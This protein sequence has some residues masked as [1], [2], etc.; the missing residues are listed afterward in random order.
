MSAEIANP[1][2]GH[3]RVSPWLSFR[4]TAKAVSNN[5]AVTSTTHAISAPRLPGSMTCMYPGREEPLCAGCEAAM[6][7]ASTRPPSVARALCIPLADSSSSEPHRKD[8]PC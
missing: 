1:T 8:L 4:S 3:S 2:V 7:V 6:D 5:P